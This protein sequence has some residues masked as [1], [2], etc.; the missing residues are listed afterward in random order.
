MLQLSTP[1]L[2]DAIRS[3][4]TLV[5][6]LAPDSD[7]TSL[8]DRFP[9]VVFARIEPALEGEVAALFGIAAGP[10]LMIF[11]EGIGLYLRPGEHG[12]GQVARLLDQILALD[13]TDVKASLE[14]E[15]SETAVNMQRMCPAA[16][17]GPLL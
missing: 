8:I 9:G 7:Q 5:V 15:R 2:H 4:G 13:M 16:R 12:A 3:S 17:R 1:E 10:A 14:R 11:R 6:R